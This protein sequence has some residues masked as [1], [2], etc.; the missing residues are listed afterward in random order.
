MR[1]NAARVARILDASNHVTIFDPESEHEEHDGYLTELAAD[2]EDMT[3]FINSLRTGEASRDRRRSRVIREDSL[4]PF[5]VDFDVIDYQSDWEA[6]DDEQAPPR[7]QQERAEQRSASEQLPPEE[8]WQGWEEFERQAMA[9]PSRAGRL[10]MHNPVDIG[11]IADAHP[12]PRGGASLA[13][14]STIGRQAPVNLNSGRGGRRTSTARHTSHAAPASSFWLH[15]SDAL[16]YSFS[17]TRTRTSEEIQRSPSPHEVLE[18]VPTTASTTSNSDPTPIERAAMVNYVL[19]Y[20]ELRDS[21]QRT[22]QT[23]YQRLS[24]AAAD[25]ARLATINAPT[26]PPSPTARRTIEE[27]TELMGQAM[28]MKKSCWLVYCGK[29][30]TSDG[31]STSLRSAWHGNASSA[32]NAASGSSEG[33]GSLVC[34]RGLVE[35]PKKVF[36]RSGRGELEEAIASDLAPCASEVGEMTGRMSWNT[37]G[38]AGCKGCAT[39]DLSC[40][41]CGNLIGYRVVNPCTPCKSSLAAPVTGL[42]W[43]YRCRAV[44]LLPRLVG[45][46]PASS[47]DLSKDHSASLLEPTPSPISPLTFDPNGRLVE[48]EPVVGSRMRWAQLPHAQIDFED[49]LV[50]EPAEWFSPET[51]NSWLVTMGSTT[52]EKSTGPSGEA[53]PSDAELPALP[54]LYSVAFGTNTDSAAQEEDAVDQGPFRESLLSP[55]SPPPMPSTWRRLPDVNAEESDTSGTP[56]SRAGLHRSG[57]IRRQASSTHLSSS[58]NG[59]GLVRRRDEDD[60]G[61]QAGEE[62]RRI[63]RRLVALNRNA[64]D[65]EVDRLTEVAGYGAAFSR[66]Q[67]ERHERDKARNSRERAGK[68]SSGA[69]VGR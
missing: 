30:Q 9:I 8:S 62:G 34:A 27:R 68:R 51:D 24:G 1:I 61:E 52:K 41:S 60:E 21:A 28:R 39:A 47:I 32:K 33:C 6:S 35:A 22:S 66:S 49:G 4:A 63:R 53:N 25:L 26:Q 58:N 7:N 2:E 20:N 67:G 46:V 10:W 18:E 15:D 37:R 57:A 23:A 42:L 19:L 5:V 54:S 65:I 45:V 14:T 29:S 31:A 56:N 48:S 17:W 43:H 38:V 40:R 16:S 12:L 36:D 55:F 59:R 13:R 44:T 69:L 11:R 3:M 64:D 50:G